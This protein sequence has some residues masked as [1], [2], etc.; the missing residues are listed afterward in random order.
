MLSNICTDTIYTYTSVHKYYLQAEHQSNDS[1][2][3]EAEQQVDD[4]KDY[5]V[6]WLDPRLSLIHHSRL[7]GDYNL[8]NKI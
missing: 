1:K 6:V 8:W 7:L 2:Y 5:V 4:G 3:E